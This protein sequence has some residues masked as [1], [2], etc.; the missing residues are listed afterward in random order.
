LRMLRS[1]G[2]G[3]GMCTGPKRC[4]CFGAGWGMGGF[5]GSVSEAGGWGFVHLCVRERKCHFVCVCVCVCV[6]HPS[7][8]FGSGREAVSPLIPSDSARL[9]RPGFILFP[10]SLSF[11]LSLA[12]SPV[13]SLSLS[14]SLSLS[15]SLYIYIY[16]FPSLLPSVPLYHSRSRSL[17]PLLL[18]LA[19]S[20]R[21][22]PPLGAPA[23]PGSSE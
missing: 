17:S 13:L 6:C 15:L 8:R 20:L 22:S 18:S 16:I 4:G 3:A 12:V 7:H 2:I 10:S 19:R 5:Q 14:R 1:R 9:I 23:H 21:P 11:S